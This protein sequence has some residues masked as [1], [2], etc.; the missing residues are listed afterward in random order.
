MR[1]GVA[2]EVL[3][4]VQLGSVSMASFSVRHRRALMEGRFGIDLPV[5]VRGRIRRLLHRYDHSFEV[6]DETGWGS[7]TDA[8]SELRSELCDLYGRDV[9]PVPSSSSFGIDDLVERGDAAHVFDALEL[10]VGH[11]RDALSF[12]RDLNEVLREEGVP[13]QLLDGELIMLDG[14]F[15][16]EHLAKRV[17]AS[18]RRVG[19]EGALRELQDARNDIVDGDAR[20]SVHNAGKSFE[21]VMKALLGREDGTAKKLAQDLRRDGYFD[22]LP[23]TLR[24]A[25][26]TE[27]LGAVPWMRN[28][29]G[30]HGMGERHVELP[31]EYANLATDLAAAYAQFLIVLKLGR[32]PV[33]DPAQGAPAIDVPVDVPTFSST[34]DDIPF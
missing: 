1:Y 11:A 17:D 16:R 12:V 27:V 21:S 7:H 20:G 29:L 26:V 18:F 6:V 19:I 4:V 28:K 2:M 13:W 14:V 9:L 5:R 8:L 24:D 30:G 34:D 3:L 23:V 31:S 25:F 32:D 22:A 10:F 15:A 33:P